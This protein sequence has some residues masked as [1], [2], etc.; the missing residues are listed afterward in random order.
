MPPPQEAPSRA[1]PVHFETVSLGITSQVVNTVR[2]GQVIRPLVFPSSSYTQSDSSEV[3]I[4]LVA[5]VYLQAH[6]HLFRPTFR[7]SSVLHS[8]RMSSTLSSSNWQPPSIPSSVG[9]SFGSWLRPNHHLGHQD[10]TK[11]SSSTTPRA[12]S[13]SSSSERPTPENLQAELP[14]SPALSAPVSLRY[15]GKFD[16]LAACAELWLYSQATPYFKGVQIA[17]VPNSIHDGGVATFAQMWQKARL[18]SQGKANDESNS[19]GTYLAEERATISTQKHEDGKVASIRWVSVEPQATAAGASKYGDD[20]SGWSSWITRHNPFSSSKMQNCL[21][22]LE[23]GK[24][25]EQ[26]AESEEKIVLLHGYGAGTG[27]FFQNI[28]GLASRP[29]SRLYAIDWLG[30]GRSSRPSYHVPASAIKSDLERVKA[31]EGFFVDSLEEWRKKAGIEKM[32]L[33]GHSLGGYLSVAF[34]LRH[35]NRVSRLVLV[36]PAGVGGDPS[37]PSESQPRKSADSPF[38][39]KNAS[40]IPESSRDNVDA[41][42]SS[43]HSVER[44]V[45]EP[46]SNTTANNQAEIREGVDKVEDAVSRAEAGSSNAVQVKKS[47]SDNSHKPPRL[48]SRT[49]TFFGWLWEQNF[50]PFGILRGSQFLGPWLMSRYT[51][52]RFGSLPEDELKALHAYCQGIFLAKGSGEYCRE[53]ALSPFSAPSGKRTEL[54]ILSCS[55]L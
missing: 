54:T 29:N 38:T 44:E 36:S 50:S 15:P 1:E 53:C 25:E 48:S 42:A 24:P 13:S 2:Q 21:N 34:A 26:G 11:S 45:L 23:I 7:L 46:Q 18:Q 14:D 39:P 47:G 6:C 49:R 40:Y 5:L 3:L 8:S 22:V 41:D 37:Q 27:F 43:V 55:L 33:V 28:A 20:P 12:S 31:A 30:M 19:K 51:Q 9:A 17:N 52:R 32:T 10:S 35:P 16:Q 4:K